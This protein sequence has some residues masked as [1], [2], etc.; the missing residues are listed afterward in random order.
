MEL[1]DFNNRWAYKGSLT[2]PPC[3]SFVYWNVLSTVYPIKEEH[4]KL[5]KDQ[6]AKDTVS[7]LATRG[8]WRITQ[9]IDNHNVMYISQTG[10]LSQKLLNFL[11]GSSAYL[12]IGAAALSA[13]VFATI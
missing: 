12:N 7:D 8:N 2:T 1:V 10:K 13:F 11:T 3:T 5:F 6:L 9:D 4:L